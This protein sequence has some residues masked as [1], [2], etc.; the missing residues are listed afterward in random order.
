M[1][2]TYLLSQVNAQVH[3]AASEEKSNHSL[4]ITR[5]VRSN[6]KVT[7]L[8]SQV[9]AQVHTAASEEKSN[10]SFLITHLMLEC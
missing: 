7:Y 10:H 5:H 6:M 9:N 1:K 3:T 2:V 4:L 8:L